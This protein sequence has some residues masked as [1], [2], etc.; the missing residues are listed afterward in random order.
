MPVLTDYIL[1][2]THLNLEYL[3]QISLTLALFT[4]HG[5][6]FFLEKNLHYQ[7]GI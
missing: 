5:N 3:Y 4:L 7:T 2:D 1:T 6:D